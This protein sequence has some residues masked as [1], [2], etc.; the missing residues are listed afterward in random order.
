MA[1]RGPP[2][3]E[4]ES[5][6]RGRLRKPPNF[7][8]LGDSRKESELASPNNS[9]QNSKSR[10]PVAGEVDEMRPVVPNADDGW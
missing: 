7:G 10:K 3:L 1:G 6:L 4:A 2:S 5:E 9:S 8:T